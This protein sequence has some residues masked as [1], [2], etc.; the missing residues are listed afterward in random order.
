MEYL[1]GYNEKRKRT[2][3]IAFCTWRKEQISTIRNEGARALVGDPRRNDVKVAGHEEDGKGTDADLCCPFAQPC[4]GPPLSPSRKGGLSQHRAA[5]RP[6]A[7]GLG[8]TWMGE[9]RRGDDGQ[10]DNG[11][12]PGR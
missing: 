3:E 2:E 6:I 5:A 1:T 8:P 12:A 11:L 7:F 10:N 9:R 4:Q